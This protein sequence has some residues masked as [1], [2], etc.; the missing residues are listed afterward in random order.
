MHTIQEL[1]EQHPDEWLAIE[2]KAEEGGRPKTGAL[3]YHA[4]DRD[5]VWRKTER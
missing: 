3:V 1:I 4:K 5:Q 2:V